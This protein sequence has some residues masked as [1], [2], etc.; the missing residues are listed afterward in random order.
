M[1]KPLFDEEY[2]KLLKC[3][4]RQ[5]LFKYRNAI[6]DELNRRGENK[7]PYATEKEELGTIAKVGRIVRRGEIFFLELIA[8][9]A[10]A[11]IIR[12]I[13]LFAEGKANQTIIIA[14]IIDIAIAVVGIIQAM[15][16]KKLLNADKSTEDALSTLAMQAKVEEYPLG[17]KL[18]DEPLD[19]LKQKKQQIDEK[20]GL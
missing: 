16:R 5:E 8:A 18:M 7:N 6:I 10:I 1:K 11:D 17:R 15:A 19:L 2:T 14:L 3:G 13:I 4:T 12:C 9:L 20:L